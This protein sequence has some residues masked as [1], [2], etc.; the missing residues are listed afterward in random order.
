M[1]VC[2][3]D[4][5]L[6]FTTRI[7]TYMRALLCVYVVCVHLCVDDERGRVSSLTV[8]EPILTKN[9]WDDTTKSN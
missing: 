9:R 3:Y 5:L 2:V 8:V 1:Y 7:H 6:S 4:G